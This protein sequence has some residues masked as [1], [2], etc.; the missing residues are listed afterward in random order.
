MPVYCLFFI[1]LDCI[2]GLGGCMLE[3]TVWGRSKETRGKHIKCII[4]MIV[5]QI[6]ESVGSIPCE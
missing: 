1:F 4:L 3:A 6:V 2:L 5:K